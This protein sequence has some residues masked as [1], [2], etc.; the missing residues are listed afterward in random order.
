MK[1]KDQQKLEE[2]YQRIAETVDSTEKETYFIYLAREDASDKLLA[3]T[4]NKQEAKEL[5]NKFKEYY[6]TNS[7]IFVMDASCNTIKLH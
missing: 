7:D 3:Q 5:L 6:G 1:S 4:T 2:A